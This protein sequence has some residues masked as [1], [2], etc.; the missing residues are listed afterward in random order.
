MWVQKLHIGDIL[1]N[2]KPVQIR[3]GPATVSLTELQY[4][5][6]QLGEGAA[7][8]MKASQETGQ[9]AG[10]CFHARAWGGIFCAKVPCCLSPRG[11]LRISIF[12]T[13]KGG[14]KR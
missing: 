8:G 13:K 11:H 3:R 12:N 4:A 9:E 5:T 10:S 2:G 14:N 7:F 1:V 6:P